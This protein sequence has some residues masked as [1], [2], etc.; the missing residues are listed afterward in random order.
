[1]NSVARLALDTGANMTLV[2]RNFITS[3][4]FN[5]ELPDRHFRIATASGIERVP[6]FTISRVEALGQERSNFPVLCHNLPQA[7]SVDGLLGLDFFRGQRLT[8]DFR[9]GLITLD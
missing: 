4:G 1:M 2:N 5:S 8:I 3:L 7:T 9:E 6:Q